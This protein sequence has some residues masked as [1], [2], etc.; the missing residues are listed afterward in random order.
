MVET[1]ITCGLL[2][3]VCQWSRNIFEVGGAHLVHGMKG[4]YPFV[5]KLGVVCVGADHLSVH[6]LDLSESAKNV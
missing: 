1:I 4:Q 2:L 6:F 5:S 3:C